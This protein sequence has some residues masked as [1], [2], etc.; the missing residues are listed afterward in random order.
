MSLRLSTRNISSKSMHAFLSNLANRQT[1]EH[2]QKH[3]PP[4]LLEV[5]TSCD[6][7]GVAFAMNNVF[8][9]LQE[10]QLLLTAPV[11][12]SDSAILIREFRLSV[13]SSRSGI[14]PKRL[15]ISSQFLYHTVAHHS[16]LMSIKHLCE[17]PTN[18]PVRPSVRDVPV[19]DEN[20]L[21]SPF[22]F[23]VR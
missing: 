21:S 19:S 20:G 15:N 22:F 8:Q 1:N 6:C 7:T 12:I 4:P 23:T 18:L 2:G 14:A 5:M 13:C 3:L 16:R 10:A 9:A 11:T 17:I